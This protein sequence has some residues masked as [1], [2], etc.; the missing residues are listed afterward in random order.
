MI[1][2]QNKIKTGIYNYYGEVVFHKKGDKYYILLED[3]DGINKK[4]ISKRFYKEAKK[5]FL[6]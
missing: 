3:W 6:K 4:E 5:E 1:K 2:M